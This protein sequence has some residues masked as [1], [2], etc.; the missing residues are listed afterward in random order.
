MSTSTELEKDGA[1]SHSRVAAS[2]LAAQIDLA[3]RA[4]EAQVIACRRYFHEH[5][6]LGN[7][8]FR[9]SAIVA[10]HLR[11]IGFDEAAPG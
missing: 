10:E 4:I 1:M 2:L 5:P 7:P 9:T 3:A 6:E 8:E 11:R